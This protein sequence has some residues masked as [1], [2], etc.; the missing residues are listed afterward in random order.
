MAEDMTGGVNIY[1]AY[2]NK[3]GVGAPLWDYSEDE[4][5][6]LMNDAINS[7]VPIPPLPRIP[8]VYF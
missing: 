8:G 4:A 6:K 1:E 2:R 5:A 7:G 3:F